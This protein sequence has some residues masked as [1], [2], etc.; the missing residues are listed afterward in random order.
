MSEETFEIPNEVDD[1]EAVPEVLRGFYSEG[2]DGKFVLEDISKLKS[3]LRHVR[4]E[5]DREKKKAAEALKKA[6]NA[7]SEEDLEELQRLRE[8]HEEREA[9]VAKKRG[10][11]DK[12]LAKMEEKQ[13][14]ALEDREQREAALKK[15]L[16]RE[17]IDSR[18]T[19]ALASAK[20]TEQGIDLLPDRLK[21]RVKLV[22]EEGH[23]N[24]IVLD[25]GGTPDINNE[26]KPKTIADLVEDA[27]G[28]YSPLFQGTGATGSGASQQPTSGGALP[29]KTKP[30]EEMSPFEKSEFISQYG[31]E[32][33]FKLAGLK[34]SHSAT[35]QQRPAR[36][37]ENP[38]R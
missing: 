8:E 6:K 32:A 38:P 7:M 22:E 5:R 3:A 19:A 34:G 20:A 36:E 18:I 33:F 24:V 10:E 23:Y 15:A 29:A 13:K 26:G 14:K 9:E 12:L 21:N 31:E 37:G 30:Y 2:E 4:D 17:M 35:T 27:K 11:F 16:E 28:K 25:E 1:L